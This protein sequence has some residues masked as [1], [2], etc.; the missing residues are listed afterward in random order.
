MWIELRTCAYNIHGSRREVA[1]VD[2]GVWVITVE[3]DWED[4]ASIPTSNLEDPK[5]GIFSR[6]ALVLPPLEYASGGL[7][8]VHPKAKRTQQF[9]KF[10]EEPASVFKKSRE[11]ISVG[12]NKIINYAYIC[13]KIFCFFRS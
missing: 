8:R 7:S 5:L 6:E 3:Q 10:C 1:A 9:W 12:S 4:G 2:V 13:H 11:Q